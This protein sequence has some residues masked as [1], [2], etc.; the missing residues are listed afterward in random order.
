V[1]HTIQFGLLS[2]ILLD[3]VDSRDGFL[4]LRIVGP[5]TTVNAI[6]ARLAAKEHRGQKWGSEVTIPVTGR[7]YPEYV[8]QQKHVTYRTLRSRLP[9]G[10]I[11][12]ALVH[13]LLT[14]AEDSPQGLY[15]LTYDH[16]V[17][18]GFF[19]RLNKSLSIPLQPEWES[20]LWQ[21]GQQP[22][23]FL[24]L[25]TKKVMEEGQYVEK[26]H[27]TEAT[28]IPISRLSSLGTVA[29]YCVRCNGRY[30]DAWLRIIRQQLGLGIRLRKEA[31]DYYRNGSW[32]ACFDKQGWLLQKDGDRVAVAPSL[33]HLL[34]EARERLGLH[35]IPIEE[36]AD[37]PVSR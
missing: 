36:E 9:S 5:E 4:Y 22:Q 31:E 17:P 23:S 20:W 30:R 13:P 35:F 6:W 26:P 33:N 11:D 21:S 3:F 12:L 32:L 16:D 24:I 2:A 15:L 14:V 10:M 25:E 27:L 19:E 29:C 1:I 34:T 7:S 28:Q 37:G 18:A 8:A